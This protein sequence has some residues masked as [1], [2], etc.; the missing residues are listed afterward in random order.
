MVT[1]PSA[2]GGSVAVRHR[3][4]TG[5]RSGATPDNHRSGCHPAAPRVPS[6]GGCA[7]D[8]WRP[9][10][11]RDTPHL[12]EAQLVKIDQ[13]SW[14]RRRRGWQ[15]ELLRRRQT[16]GPSCMLGSHGILIGSRERPA[17][18]PFWGFAKSTAVHQPDARSDVSPAYV[19]GG[20]PMGSTLTPNP[21]WV[22]WSRRWNHSGAR[23]AP[24]RT[25]RFRPGWS[26]RVFGWITILHTRVPQ[27]RCR[28]GPRGE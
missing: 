17:D 26:R 3:A 5:W 22:N 21:A 12:R 7:R 15:F 27:L 8:D 1:R 20:R 18:D 14:Q 11:W 10:K 4:S 16:S 6:R 28:S 9:P 23:R 25:R 19:L 13:R 24:P 2:A